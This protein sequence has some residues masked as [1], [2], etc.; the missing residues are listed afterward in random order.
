MRRRHS[1]GSEAALCGKGLC[2]NETEDGVIRGNIKSFRE[3]VINAVYPPACP[4]CGKPAPY[5]S[6]VRLDICEECRNR[7]VYINEDRCLKCGKQLSETESEYC[8]DCHR[9]EHV[10]EQGAAVFA[11]SEGIK[12]SVYRYKYKGCREYAA[13]YS[14]QIK[15]RCGLLIDE[16]APQVIIPVPLHADRLRIRGYNQA[17]LMAEELGRL[18][19]IRTDS[20][21]LARAK[22]T[23]PMKLLDEQERI[24][25]LEKAFIVRG[26]VVKYKKVLLIDDIYTTGATADACAGVLKDCGAES[27]FCLS[28]CIGRGIG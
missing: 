2:L 3:A 24:K 18:T 7:L 26:N 15:E 10:F 19:G 20:K 4:V 21:L 17:E 8:Y 13:W 6:G 28:L 16:W 23:K 11:Y 25:N 27:V 1:S 9:A 22:K 14:R 12:Q 5:V